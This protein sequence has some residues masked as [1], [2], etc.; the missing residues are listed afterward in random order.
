MCNSSTTFSG[1]LKPTLLCGIPDIVT[2]HGDTALLMDK[3]G[4]SER[5]LLKRIEDW[6]AGQQ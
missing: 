3:M 2:E 5:A 4:L 1:C 6:L